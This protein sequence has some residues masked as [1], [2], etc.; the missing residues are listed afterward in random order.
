[1][2]TDGYRRIESKNRVRKLSN[3][4]VGGKEGCFENVVRNSIVLGH[5]R[6]ARFRDKNDVNFQVFDILLR[7]IFA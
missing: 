2:Y 1:M 4:V 6:E 7:T 5:L 3:S